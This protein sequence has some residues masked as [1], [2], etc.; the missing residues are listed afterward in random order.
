MTVVHV[1]AG[2]V[3]DGDLVGSAEGT[4]VDGLHVVRV[5]GDVADVAEEA[6]PLAVGGDVDALAGARA[7]EQ[8]R[9]GA[10]L[11][12]DGVAAV[13]RIPDEGVVAGAHERQVVASVAVGRVVAV[14]AEHVLDA[15]AAGDRVVCCAAVQGQADHPGCE[16]RGRNPVV[17]AETA[18]LELVARLRVP[19]RHHRR[20]GRT[21]RRLRRHR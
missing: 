10:V 7:V 17:A 19:N 11:A 4:E 1:G 9:V 6:Q 5:H 16:R 18:D 12:F 20:A 3:V 13:A 14:A 21:R 2:E 15:P 8:H